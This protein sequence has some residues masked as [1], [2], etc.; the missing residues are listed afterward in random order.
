MIREFL[1]KYITGSRLNRTLLSILVVWLV[2]RIAWGWFV[3]KNDPQHFVVVEHV[4]AQSKTHTQIKAVKV[5]TT[6]TMVN[7]IKAQ[8][9]AQVKAD[10]IKAV[11]AAGKAAKK[12]A[13]QS[14]SMTVRRQPGHFFK[15]VNLTH[16]WRWANEVWFSEYEEEGASTDDSVPL[17]YGDA[18]TGNIS[19]IMLYNFMDTIPDSI[20]INLQRNYRD[21]FNFEDRIVRPLNVDA[22]KITA[23]LMTSEES[24]TTRKKEFGE[25]A[26]DQLTNGNYNTYAKR[27]TIIDFT[28]ERVV[29]DVTK[30]K[31]A[32]DPVTRQQIPVRSKEKS[33][34]SWGI[35]VP[36][37]SLYEPK[38]EPRV[39]TMMV[40]KLSS[41]LGK[42]V[43]LARTKYENRVNYKEQISGQV[44]V[45]K[46]KYAQE[47]T[48]M[49]MVVQSQTNQDTTRIKSD[50]RRQVARIGLSV[51]SFKREIG[52][53]Q[54]DKELRV[55]QLGMEA[56]KQ[57][58]SRLD[59]YVKIQVAKADAFAAAKQIFPRAIVSGGSGKDSSPILD[60]FGI[61]Q[62]KQ[63]M[64][65]SKSE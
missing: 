43:S 46:Q 56:D 27:D 2:V 54:G 20:L 57:L 25:V 11:A 5:D 8:T 38:Y 64:N 53:L 35:E 51:A 22:L 48:N 34:G 62:V 42:V 3:A 19:G 12:A 15:W 39:D 63:L 65:G 26:Q 9:K 1:R 10:S 16:R 45:L 40:R 36:I 7:A 13:K 23:A 30:V 41:T 58:T 61:N 28:G 17:R 52:Q 44:D 33:L 31:Y 32:I 6:K 21:Q 60:I 24:Y 59:T 50:A 55:R 37:Y 4:M 29:A 18:A 49:E 14:V 47:V